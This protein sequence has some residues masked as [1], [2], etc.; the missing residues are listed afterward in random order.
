MPTN[1]TTPKMQRRAAE[2][3]RNQTEAEARL[4]AYLRAHRA[5]GVHFRRQHAIGYF[6]V[7]FCAPRV[8]LIV[9]V[10]GGQHIEQGEYDTERTRFLESQGYTVLRFWNNVILKDIDAVMAVILEALEAGEIS[11]MA[12]HADP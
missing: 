12:H 1:R 11:S 6:V 4:W 7:D 5:N 9:E 3:R 8:K 10:D 2:L